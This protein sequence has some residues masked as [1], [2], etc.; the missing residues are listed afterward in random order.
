MN[1]FT[2]MVFSNLPCS[3]NCR[4]GS[5]S[6]HYCI[7]SSAKF[8]IGNNATRAEA[9]RPRHSYTGNITL[10]S[11]VEESLSGVATHGGVSP[12]IVQSATAR[13]RVHTSIAE[14]WHRKPAGRRSTMVSTSSNQ[15]H[16]G[17]IES[18]ATRK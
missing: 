4:N 18:R 1:I 2:R 6:V 14:N 7:S 8:C 15:R 3:G 17:H 13:H 9:Q 10:S 16:G 12:C 11:A 5:R